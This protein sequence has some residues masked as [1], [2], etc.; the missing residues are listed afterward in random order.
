[1]ALKDKMKP[2]VLTDKIEIGYPGLAIFCFKPQEGQIADFEAGQYMTIGDDVLQLGAPG[3]TKFVPRP[4]S[5]SSSPLVKNSIEFYIVEVDAGAFTPHLFRKKIGETMWYMGPKGKFILSRTTLKHLV[6]ICTGTG[7]A[8]FISMLRTLKIQNRAGELTIT[9]MHGNR[10]S[11]E[12]GYRDELRGYESDGDFDFVYMPTVSRPE[13]DKGMDASIGRGR[14]NDTLRH[15]LGLP[16]QGKVEPVLPAHQSR[17]AVATRMPKGQ[18]AFFLCGN[19]DMIVDG[20]AAI[21]ETGM[22]ST[23][24]IFTEDYW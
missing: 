8:P 10:T 17:D 23:D 12:L 21:A 16:K 14:V 11:V 6:F 22:A 1:M 3:A 18:T 5:V 20:K 13:G 15:A 2:L 4:Y 9:L 24:Q 19:P 7:L